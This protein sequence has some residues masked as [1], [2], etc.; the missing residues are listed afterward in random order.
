METIHEAIDGAAKT[1]DA[2]DLKAA[3]L[4]HLY[5][6][7][8]PALVAVRYPRGNSWVFCL[9]PIFDF[10]PGEHLRAPG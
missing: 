3:C 1:G 5:Y 2:A 8:P 9:P 7:V 6:R 10:Y 4:R